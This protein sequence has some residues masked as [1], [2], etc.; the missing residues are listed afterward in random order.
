MRPALNHFKRLRQEM[1]KLGIK[2]AEGN[3][4]YQAE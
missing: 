3:Q 1:N 2:N 4:I